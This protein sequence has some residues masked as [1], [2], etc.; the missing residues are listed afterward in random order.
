MSMPEDKIVIKNY[1]ELRRYV[2][3]IN[4]GVMFAM[5][6]EQEMD[7]K[8]VILSVCKY[9]FKIQDEDLIVLPA[10]KIGFPRRAII[11]GLLGRADMSPQLRKSLSDELSGS[12]L[13]LK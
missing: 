10:Y 2:K 4:G 8:A 7:A 3:S 12:R 5:I 9:M 1:V 13:N 11:R 6:T